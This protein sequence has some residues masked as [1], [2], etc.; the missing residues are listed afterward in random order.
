MSAGTGTFGG[1][2]NTVHL[3]S[4]AGVEDWPTLSKEDVAERLVLGIAETLE[5]AP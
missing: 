4:A 3:V 5:G 2:S 1:D